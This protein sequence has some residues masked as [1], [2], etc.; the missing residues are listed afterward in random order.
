MQTVPAKLDCGT[1]APEYFHTPKQLYRAIYYKALDL[2][3]SL[4]KDR[5]DQH[6]YN[7]Y[8]NYEQLLLK[9]AAGG[10]AYKDGFKTVISSYGSDFDPRELEAHLSTF[11]QWRINQWTL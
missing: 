2:I 4:I 6:D 10:D 3:V 11:I 9:A 8:M 7:V 5:F 1:A